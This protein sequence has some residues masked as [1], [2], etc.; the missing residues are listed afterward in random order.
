[1]TFKTVPITA[2]KV[3]PLATDA[4]HVK[5]LA[6]SIEQLGGELINPITVN[7]QMVLIA[8]AH[9][10][11]AARLAGKTRI[12]VK[13]VDAVGHDAALIRLDEN[14]G[15]KHRPALELAEML[16]E[17][18]A[19]Y[20]LKH[21]DAPKRG[22]DR[23]KTKSV[24]SATASVA[25]ETGRT[26][27]SVQQYVAVAEKLAPKAKKKLKGTEAANSITDLQR[28]AKLEPEH[29]VAV[30][31]RVAATGETVKQAAKALKREEQVLQARVYVPPQGE[32][33]VIT[34][35]YPWEYDDQL[36]GS[37]AVRGGCPYPPMPIEE[38]CAFPIPCAKDCALFVWVTNQHMIDGS[39][40][41]VRQSLADRYAFVPKGLAT[42]DKNEMGTGWYFRNQTEHLVLLVRGKPVFTE[43]K[44][45]SLIRAPLG[46]HSE[47]PAAFYMSIERYCASTSRLEMF[48]RAPRQGW[49]TTG[50]ELEQ[51]LPMF[52]DTPAGQ[53]AVAAINNGMAP[54]QRKLKITDVTESP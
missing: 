34:T 21:P 44:L 25:K 7:K 39:Y 22:G 19:A 3:G 20:E 38:I 35:D 53:A 23:S 28:L 11:R 9:R 49:V 32:F 47:K 41:K 54:K 18:K 8:G 31:E 29:Q 14:L 30:A 16:R 1:V 40:D 45:R 51:K 43:E 15:Q 27:R 52:I 33:E 26:E 37:D 17:R 46:E 50:S 36:D 24:R 4:D 5:M 10:Y 2:V 12:D 42:W 6:E 13:I 48:A